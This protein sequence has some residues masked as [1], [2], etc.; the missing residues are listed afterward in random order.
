MPQ[1]DTFAG[2]SPR[3]RGNR[4]REITPSEAMR[5][6]PARAGEPISTAHA[7][8]CRRVYPRACGGT[9][10]PS[11]NLSYIVGLSPRVRGNPLVSHDSPLRFRSIPARAGEPAQRRYASAHAAVYPRACGGTGMVCSLDSRNSGLSPRVRGNPRQA[12]C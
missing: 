5:S 6:I 10:S 8:R 3:V 2:L 1:Q 11:L 12:R 4:Y 7:D 9:S